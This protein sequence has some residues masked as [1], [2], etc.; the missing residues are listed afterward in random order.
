MELPLSGS[1]GAAALLPPRAASEPG[2]FVFAPCAPALAARFAT[3]AA[4]VEAT[5][6]GGGGAAAGARAARETHE[7]GTPNL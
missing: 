6:A 1:D 2:G 5:A 3:A 4:A 7:G